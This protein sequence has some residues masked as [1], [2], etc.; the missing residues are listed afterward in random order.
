MNVASATAALQPQD[1]LADHGGRKN[2]GSTHHTAEQDSGDENQAMRTK[3]EQLRLIMEQRR[4]RRKARRDA[5]A[6]PYPT[7]PSSWTSDTTVPTVVTTSSTT[8]SATQAMDVDSGT[9][10]GTDPATLCEL[11]SETVVA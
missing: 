3:V 1:N 5:R 8:T 10:E 6:R 11:N 2:T 4:A 7:T 9:A